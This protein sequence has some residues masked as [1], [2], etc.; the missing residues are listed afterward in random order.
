MKNMKRWLVAVC[1]AAVAVGV[2]VRLN[3]GEPREASKREAGAGRSVSVAPIQGPGLEEP[4]PPPPGSGTEEVAAYERALEANRSGQDPQAA[5]S[6]L[7]SPP[8]PREEIHRRIEERRKA[9]EERRKQSLE[10]I[11]KSREE[12][13]KAREANGG[14]P[15]PPPAR[16][17]PP[18][19]LGP[20]VVEDPK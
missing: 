2:I 1:V 15:K 11:E 7:R 3:A 9:A 18:P 20:A 6:E 13:R 14:N 16:L 5:R 4:L 17:V 12:A 10:R 8:I 19:D